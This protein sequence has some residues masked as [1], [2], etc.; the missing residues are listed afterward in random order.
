MVYLFFCHGAVAMSNEISRRSFLAATAALGTAASIGTNAVAEAPKPVAPASDRL[1]TKYRF[2]DSDMDLFFVAALG[3]GNTGGL[4]IGQAFYV[5]SQ[6]T[7]GDPDSW[8]TA[9]GD[10]GARLDAQA[11]EWK[12]RGWALAAAETR[13]KAFA[14]YR[15]AW[16]FAAVGPV[17]ADLYRKHKAAFAEA[18]KEL[19]FPAT[20]FNAPY[21]SKSLPGVF[22]RNP[23]PAAPTILIV[24]GA[25]TCFEDMFLTAG[26]NMFDQ[27]FSVAIADLPGQGITMADDL[28]WEIEA[29][30]PISAIVDVLVEKFHVSPRR[31]SLLGTSLG[32]YFVT[33][34]AGHEPRFSAVIA[35]TAFPRPGE[36]FSRAAERQALPDAPPRSN[37]AI[38]N[39]QVMCWKAGVSD[40]TEL[41]A[42]VSN[43]ISDPSIVTVPFLA[44]AGTGESPVFISQAKSWIEQIRSPKKSL[45]LL[46][47]S[48]GGDGHCQVANRLRLAQEAAGWLSEVL[49]A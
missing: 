14:A 43:M 2:N 49:S 22:I 33:R 36:L 37:A 27:G 48:T 12:K 32:G 9:F 41:L 26:R 24:G 34:A 15:S 39:R 4:D 21:K 28:H 38:R 25:D 16:Q 45:V 44:V 23:N 1:S 47:R 6:I 31:L 11:D 5:A 13:L 19:H 20:F 40:E 46:D 35:S 3:W 10:H 7:D 17:F 42:R 30:K 18:I 29:E 8:V